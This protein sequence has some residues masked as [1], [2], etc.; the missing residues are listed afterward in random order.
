MGRGDLRGPGPGRGRR[1]ASQPESGVDRAGP[2]VGDEAGGA[3]FGEPGLEDPDQ[4]VH[5]GARWPRRLRHAPA[6]RKQFLVPGLGEGAAGRGQADAARF[7]LVNR[8]VPTEKVRKEA[9]AMARTIAAKSR[10]T[11]AIGKEAFYRQIDMPLSDAYDYA[12]DVMVRNM[13]AADA[14]EGI[15]AFLE[16]RP[17]VWKGA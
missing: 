14:A 9:L 7:G 8:V 5:G 3:R 12:A 1:H 6:V 10:L 15:C 13:M 2:D 4:A 17:P 16:K 11:V